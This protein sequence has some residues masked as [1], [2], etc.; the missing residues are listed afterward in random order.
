MRLSALFVIFATAVVICFHISRVHAAEGQHL[1][2]TLT[3]TPGTPSNYAHTLQNVARLANALG[4]QAKLLF[5]SSSNGAG[6][7][8]SMI[9]DWAIATVDPNAM[10]GLIGY[11]VITAPQGVV[12][13]AY[14]LHSAT[15][16]LANET[17]EYVVFVDETICYPLDVDRIASTMTALG[18]AESF[19]WDVLHASVVCAWRHPQSL[20]HVN[21]ETPDSVVELCMNQGRLYNLDNEIVDADDISPFP[22]VA[23]FYGASHLDVETVNGQV[24]SRITRWFNGLFIARA[25]SLAILGC[26]PDYESPSTAF[27]GWTTC[28]HTNGA[29]QI[30]ASNFVATDGGCERTEV[31]DSSECLPFGC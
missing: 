4:A 7:A 13:S 14:A 1:F 17:F 2:V 3:T 27:D 11:D 15:E 23:N 29:E 9:D 21:I 8:Q 5:V 25:D 30:W 28:L 6:E 26:T 31:R 10:A 16:R 18:S 20:D 22:G 12:V 19:G 24:V